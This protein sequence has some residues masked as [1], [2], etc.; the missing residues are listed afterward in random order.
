MAA[1]LFYGNRIFRKY[2]TETPLSYVGL[3]ITPAAAVACLAAGSAAGGLAAS[4][5]HFSSLNENE[6]Q[7]PVPTW[8]LIL[9]ILIQ[10]LLREGTGKRRS[11]GHFNFSEKVTLQLCAYIFLKIL[12]SI[13]EKVL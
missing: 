3:L 8:T 10:F 12:D 13:F 2:N 7:D 1:G 6:S 11:R 5:F 9:S 4:L